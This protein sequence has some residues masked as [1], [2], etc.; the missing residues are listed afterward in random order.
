M[1]IGIRPEHIT[2]AKE[3]AAHKLTSTVEVVEPMGFE[4][5]VYLGVD[6]DNVAGAASLVCRILEEHTPNAGDIVSITADAEK[7]HVFDAKS[8]L[9][10]E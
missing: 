9:R 4:S 10:L 1:I 8:E 5:Y 3:G 7:I 2:I 6:K